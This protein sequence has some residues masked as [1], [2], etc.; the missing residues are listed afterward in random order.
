MLK[1][2]DFK[3]ICVCA[4]SGCSGNFGAGGGSL[5]CVLMC[6]ECASDPGCVHLD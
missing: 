6:M 5:V 3:S 2:K 4:G 1:S